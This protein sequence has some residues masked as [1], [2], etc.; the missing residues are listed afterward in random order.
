MITQ[1]W[2]FWYIT[3]ASEGKIQVQESK[4]EIDFEGSRFILVEQ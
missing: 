1:S 4:E 2:Q 3:M